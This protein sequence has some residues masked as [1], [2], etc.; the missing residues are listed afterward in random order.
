MP[1]TT[2]S[3]LHFGDL[4]K[5]ARNWLPHC[6]PPFGRCMLGLSKEGNEFLKGP[7]QMAAME[8]G[9]SAGWSF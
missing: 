6:V 1:S 9:G 8:K 5:G 2:K 7:C 3:D 4:S